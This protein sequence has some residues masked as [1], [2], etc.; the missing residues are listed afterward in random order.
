VANPVPKRTEHFVRRVFAIFQAMGFEVGVNLVPGRSQKRTHDGQVNAIH[1]TRCN[2]PHASEP[3][4]SRAP[5]Q[6]EEKCFDE[7]SGVMA[8][9]NCG[10][11]PAAGDARE[12]IVTRISS[13]SFDRLLRTTGEGKDIE[14]VDLG[15]QIQLPG[16]GADELGVSRARASA[17]LVIEMADKETV[18][19][20]ARQRV[21]QRY[22]IA[23]ARHANQI[24]AGRSK[25]GKDVWTD[26]QFV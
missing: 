8:E 10:A 5:K 3:G 13:G 9:K 14:P 1:V 2:L 16:E 26:G 19:S 4:R 6:I 25:S 7:V 18:I 11:T 20:Q 15:F 17:Q 24:A 21:E 22:G 12:K 23:T